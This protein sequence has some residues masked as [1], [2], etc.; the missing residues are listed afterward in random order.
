M[1]VARQTFAARLSFRPA[2]SNS[3]LTIY[4]AKF[5]E[6]LTNNFQKSSGPNSDRP[7]N[8]HQPCL[9][10][11]EDVGDRGWDDAESFPS[12]VRHG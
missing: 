8:Q 11:T 1:Q 2:I 3:P 7:E 6:K 9:S 10:D 12:V 5:R 4:E